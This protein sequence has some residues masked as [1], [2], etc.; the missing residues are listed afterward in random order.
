MYVWEL[1][2]FLYC[3]ILPINNLQVVKSPTSLPDCLL[4]ILRPPKMRCISILLHFTTQVS[5]V[6]EPFLDLS[7]PIVDS[8]RS[9]HNMYN[10]HN[11]KNTQRKKDEDKEEARTFQGVCKLLQQNKGNSISLPLESERS[12]DGRCNIPNCLSEYTDLEVMDSDNMFIC[13]ECN[14]RENMVSIHLY[15]IVLMLYSVQH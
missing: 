14:R 15:C 12:H 10:Q 4:N 3:S 7:L 1:S 11:T 9:S 13:T 6:K 8:Q 2:V 5:Q